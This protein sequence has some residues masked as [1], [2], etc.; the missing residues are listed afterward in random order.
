[1]TAANCILYRVITD[2]T[3]TEEYEGCGCLLI[4]SGDILEV[5]TPVQLEDG[6]EQQP[7]GEIILFVILYYHIYYIIFAI[8]VCVARWLRQGSVV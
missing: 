2:F 8:L 4:K 5:E 3:P 1:M 6:T 7:K